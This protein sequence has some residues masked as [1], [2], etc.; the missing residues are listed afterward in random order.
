M[1]SQ[2]K[3]AILFS[4]MFKDNSLKCFKSIDSTV[5]LFTPGGTP[6][7]YNI[8]IHICLHNRVDPPWM[9]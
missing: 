5:Q 9:Y 1:A 4:C 7:H 3:L 8:Q 2:L 6:I